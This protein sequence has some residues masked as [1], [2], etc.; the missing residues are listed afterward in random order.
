[1]ITGIT[2]MTLKRRILCRLLTTIGLFVKS[3][4]GYKLNAKIFKVGS[5]TI[6]AT[7]A[8]GLSSTIT[9]AFPEAFANT[10]VVIPS[11][12]NPHIITSVVSRSTSSAAFQAKNTSAGAS[13][14][15]SGT[16]IAID[17]GYIF[18]GGATFRSIDARIFNAFGLLDGRC[19]A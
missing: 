5:F 7:T 4:T 15:L 9:V 3:G 18:G 1:M 16:W 12:P 17:L 6:P 10:P 11:S 8:G 2:D 19:A 14:A 13:I